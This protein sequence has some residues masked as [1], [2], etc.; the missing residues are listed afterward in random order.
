MKRHLAAPG[1]GGGD[2]ALPNKALQAILI[3]GLG[4]LMSACSSSPESVQATYVSQHEYDDYDCE[5]LLRE[6][7]LVNVRLQE[8]V[9]LQ[10]EAATN[11]IVGV[12][13]G[14]LF[15]PLAGAMLLGEDVEEELALQ[16][17]RMNAV[18]S[19]GIA[20]KCALPM[21]KAEEEDSE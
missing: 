7:E 17:G 2:A 3:V 11:D 19:A 18:Q 5:A 15:L 10:G 13:G 20:K 16:K 14:L 6:H 21:P 1:G 8:L 12:A 9:E 4:M